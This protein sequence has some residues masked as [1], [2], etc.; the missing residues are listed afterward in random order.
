MRASAIAAVALGA[1]GLILGGVVVAQAAP[2]TGTVKVCTTKKNVVVSATKSG[3]C[4][5]G[6]KKVTLN[7]RGPVGPAG[8]RG[9]TGARGPAGAQ[10]PAGTTAFGKETGSFA[11]GAGYGCVLGEVRLYAGYVGAGVP[12]N[13]QV[14]PISTNTALFSLLGTRYGGNGTTTFALPDLRAAAPNGLTYFICVDG[15][16]PARVD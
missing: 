4:A 11:A 1:G 2:T 6:L 5:K 3:R 8:A 14:L 12:A 15:T 7:T 9:A 10:G 13:G 16:F